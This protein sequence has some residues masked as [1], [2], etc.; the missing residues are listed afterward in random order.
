[1]GDGQAQVRQARLQIVPQRRHGRRVGLLKARQDRRRGLPARIVARRVADGDEM[2]LHLSPGDVGDLVQDIAHPMD[3][4]AD[5]QALGP[6]LFDRTY[7]PR[8][9]V[10]GDAHRRL[11]PAADHVPQ[12]P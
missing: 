3:P 5:P 6:R 1:M 8:R 7:Q 12:H 9:S 2:R 4:A 10:T 11:Q